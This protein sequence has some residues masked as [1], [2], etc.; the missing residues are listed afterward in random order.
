MKYLT[1]FATGKRASL[2]VLFALA[3][4]IVQT[5][6]AQ[7]FGVIYNFTGG[8]DGGNPLAGFIQDSAGNMY[9]TT[10]SGG[11]AGNGV[12]FK[13]TQAGQETVLY[14]FQ[15]WPTDGANPY[16]GLL[17]DSA[18]NLYG[19]TNSGGIHDLGAI[20]KLSKNGHETLLHSFAV[21]N[22]GYYPNS[23]LIM[24]GLGNLYGTTTAGGVYGG[25]AVFELTRSGE[26]TVLYSFGN[27]TDG[28]TPVAGVTMDSK[29]NLYGTTSLGGTYSYGV[30]FQLV[31][32]PLETIPY[33]PPSYEWKENVLYNFTMQN[34]GGVPYAGVIFDHAGNLYGAATEGGQG[35][36][37]GGGTVFKLSPSNGV[38]NFTLL[39]DLSG[40]NISGTYQD[41][42]LDASGNIWATTHCDGD[43]QAGTVYELSPSNGT[44]S[45]NQ[46]YEF[47]GGTDGLYSFSNIVTDKQG[48][49]YGT[50][51]QGGAYGYGVV[52]KVI[53]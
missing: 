7:S 15:G 28:A 33:A 40:W 46:L 36:T 52:F 13:V 17:M 1:R 16:A 6:E 35:G 51:K 21:T 14:N 27:G 25:G 49:L 20:F 18:G 5:V 29:G 43:D 32:T 26:E 50:T 38:W 9:G 23:G 34:D 11:S 4:M 2:L 41:L 31:R 48:N 3:A 47:T 44:W 22:D 42:L 37:N 45:Y 12:V 39:Y 8:S 10:S 19:T 53:P 30:V 24:D